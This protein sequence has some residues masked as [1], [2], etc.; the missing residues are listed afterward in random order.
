MIYLKYNFY[1][2][3]MVLFIIL[4]LFDPISADGG[5]FPVK[6]EQMGNSAESPNQRA[7]IIYNENR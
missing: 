1:N 5:F 3:I 4:M 6:V 7:I 2:F